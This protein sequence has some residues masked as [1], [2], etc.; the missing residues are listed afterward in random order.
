MSESRTIKSLK[1]AQVSLFYYVIQLILGFWSRK[2][3]LDYLGVEVLGLDTTASTLFGFLNLAELGIGIAVGYFLY[4]P[5]YDQNHE[6]INK[7][8]AL[9]GWIYKRVA[10][11]IILGA[12]ILMCFFPLIFK[13][14][15]L[16]L[17]YAYATFSVMLFGSMLGYFIN[18]KSIVLNTDQKGYKVTIATQ[19]FG[20]G[21]K[22]LQIILLPIVFSPFLFYLSTT[23]A[24]QVFGCLWLNRVIKKEY[25]WLN[26]S[27]YNGKELLKEFPEVL[28]KTKQLFIHRIT[29]VIVFQATPLVMYAFSSLSIVGSYGNYS[30]ILDRIVQVIRM[31]YSSMAAAVGNLI[32][33][34][35]K[36]KIQRV[37]WELYDSR[38]CISTIALICVYFL[39]HPFFALWIGSQYIL[40]KT[41]LCLLLI[42]LWFQLTRLTVDHYINGYG[43][44]QDVWAPGVEGIINLGGS[45][46]FG[47]LWGFKGVLMG[48][49]LSQLVII[50]IWK[51]YM[52]FTRGI[53]ESPKSYFL[54]V[55]FRHLLIVFDMVIF[56]F[57]FN[58]IL[59]EAFTSYLQFFGYAIIVFLIITLVISGEFWLFSQGTKDF[60]I[61]M[62]AVATHKL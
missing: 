50:C 54:P 6:T 5:M 20:V 51:P 7:I 14:T 17:W 48:S 58:P 18:Y 13:D 55:I 9:Q 38:F 3:F 37:F 29:G 33:S 35:D 44:F 12:C 62:K 41:F 43:L 36:V 49:I 52:L 57:L 11:I 28:K 24:S 40:G 22:I 61:R 10:C 4:K 45:L 16:P 30:V 47:Y 59:P 23:V 2:V 1:N 26:T 42:N 32:A 39:V 31:V 21:I 60:L 27:G 19:G 34:G 15:G 46:L 25:P 53:K 56:T 8:V